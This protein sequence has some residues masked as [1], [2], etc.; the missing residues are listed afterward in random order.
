VWLFPWLSFA[1]LALVRP[2]WKVDPELA[3][4]GL[5]ISEMRIPAMRDRLRSL[6]SS[7]DPSDVHSA[8][9]I[10]RAGSR[11]F[12]VSCSVIAIPLVLVRPLRDL[13]VH[14]LLITAAIT[15]VIFMLGLTL[16]EARLR[17]IRVKRLRLWDRPLL[18]WDLAFVSAGLA[19]CWRGGLLHG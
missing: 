8:V 9:K 4:M 12:V 1:I 19:L 5:G 13:H 15:G 14:Q 6:V 11:W 3:V 2:T 16:Q 17:W 18:V 10:L 7:T